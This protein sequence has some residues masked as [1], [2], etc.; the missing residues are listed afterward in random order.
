MGTILEIINVL[1][2]NYFRMTKKS[3]LIAGAIAGIIIVGGGSFYAGISYAKSST[4]SRGNF[5]GQF[6]GGNRTFTAGTRGGN[7]GFT[8]GQLLNKDDKSITISVQGGG[9]K[10]VLLS[11]STQI[12]KSTSGSESDLSNGEQVV[13]TGSP[14]SDGSVTAQTIQI[15]PS[16]AGNTNSGSAAKTQ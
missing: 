7:G 8:A 6:G 10:I 15:R 13:V 11:Q 14:N 5:S 4:P 2:N 1:I 12:M 3:K 16:M 9:S